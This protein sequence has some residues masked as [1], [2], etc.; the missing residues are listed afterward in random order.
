MPFGSSHRKQEAVHLAVDVPIDVDVSAAVRGEPVGV[1][2]MYLW[3]GR[4]PSVGKFDVRIAPTHDDQFSSRP[5]DRVRPPPAP[6][7][8][9]SVSGSSPRPRTP[10]RSRSTASKT[11]AGNGSCAPPA[12]LRR[13]YGAYPRAE[14]ATRSTGGEADPSLRGR[15]GLTADPRSGRPNVPGQRTSAALLRRGTTSPAI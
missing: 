13:P 14:I 9:P 1:R 15:A 5:H 6:W 4:R 10:R 3:T 8:R 2:A 12:A 11:A 7:G